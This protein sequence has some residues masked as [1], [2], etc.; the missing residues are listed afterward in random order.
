MP[1]IVYILLGSNLG[2]R[3]Q[4][5]SAA[6]ERIS[7]LEGCELIASSSIYISD[8][9]DMPVDSPSFLNQVLKV[10]YT[11][12]P[13][14]LLH[15]LEKIE[16]DLGRSDKGKLQPRSVDCDILLFGNQIIKSEKLTVPHAKLTQRPFAMVPL[17]EIDSALV[18]P[19]HKKTIA[20]FLTEKGSQS[21]LLYKDHVARTN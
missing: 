2:D 12:P 13:L 15:A 6:R 20:S 18:H 8:A 10:E 5:L 21:V 17:L 3:E 16:Q 1:E 14:E 11:Y 7:A 9:V 4:N 19:A